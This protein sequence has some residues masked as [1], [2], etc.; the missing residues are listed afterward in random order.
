M[1]ITLVSLLFILL[2]TSCDDSKQSK[3]DL[4]QFIPRK[5]SVIIKTENWESF[6]NAIINCEP[7]QK[8]SEFSI[9]KYLNNKTSPLKQLN[10]EGQ[11][12]L[13]FVPT[14]KND[15]DLTFILEK[16]NQKDS[17]D[18]RKLKKSTYNGNTILSSTEAQQPFYYT[19][20]N[21]I[22]IA[23]TS[24]I[25]IENAIRERNADP[26]QEDLAFKQLYNISSTNTTGTIFINGK[27]VGTIFKELF[28][29]A[30]SKTFQNTLDWAA[31][32]VS[33]EPNSIQL[34]GIVKINENESQ[35]LGLLKGTKPNKSTI[36]TVTPINAYGAI[37]LNYKNWDSYKNNLAQAKKIPLKNFSPQLQPLLTISDEVAAIYKDDNSPMVAIRPTDMLLSQEAMAGNR[38]VSE[39]FREV[40]I[41]RF[42]DSL[43]LKKTFDKL[44]T[45]P[46]VNFYAE[47][48]EYLIFT[49]DATQLKTLIANY[50][51]NAVLAKR[52][53][54]NEI[55]Q[56]LSDESSM[57]FIGNNS[58]LKTHLKTLVD[59]SENQK[60][61]N[62][63]I[64][65]YPYL[66]AQ[67]IQDD[68]FLHFH[69]RIE[70]NNIAVESGA[71]SQIASVQLNDDLATDPQ[72]VKNHRNKGMDVV[73]QDIQDN[74]YLISNTGKILWQK[75]VS[76]RI[77][78]PIHQVDL[79]KNGRL[80]LAFV[81]GD[82]FYILDRNGK[83]V[84][85]FP[86]KFKDPITQPLS[87]FDYDTNRN[88]RFI[89][90]QDKNLLMYD[91]DA[92][93][94][95]GFTYTEA[96]SHILFPPKH[97]RIGTKDYIVIAQ[98]NG[99]LNI[100]DRTG[101][102]RIAV[103]ETLDFGDNNPYEGN[104]EFILYDANANKISISQNGKLEKSSSTLSSNLIYTRLE[105]IEALIS[106]NNL[107]INQNKI[108]LDYGSYNGLSITPIKR[109]KYITVTDEQAKRVYIFDSKGNLLPNFPVYGSSSASIGLLERNKSFGFAVKGERNTVLLY[110]ITE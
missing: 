91:R 22:V 87:V 83:E 81:T 57:L 43:A 12:L 13:S 21:N 106:D 60:I 88:Y 100:L 44:L 76:G 108:E 109:N 15:Y 84:S 103:K 1:R 90:T 41:Y 42:T 32:D 23:S 97:I 37:S 72:L 102:T 69:G 101:D 51:N 35:V 47:I 4:T 94:V 46:P 8:L 58:K 7:A 89:V 96:P 48:G 39:V 53:D 52:S 105:D 31:I 92:S 79:Y 77:L 19:A 75:K 71:I 54:F 38:E 49:Q 70:K 24:K 68:N 5:S 86:L 34:N 36:A 16:S 55:A 110:K 3:N 66:I 25:L 10:P 104:K 27:Y 73:V 33:L 80:Q 63:E 45:V 85:P 82:T 26:T 2:C 64:E 74:L 99:T 29:Q 65:E 98:Q 59:D 28:K 11:V 95:R 50:K 56:R 20:L 14:G 61:D 93:I 62:L 18:I 40:N 107:Q 6:T 17:I 30:K 78:G 67:L 9:Y